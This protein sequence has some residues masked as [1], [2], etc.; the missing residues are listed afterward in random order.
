MRTKQQQKSP[1]CNQKNKTQGTTTKL[2]NQNYKQFEKQKLK[3][4]IQN[5]QN[6]RVFILHFRPANDV[7]F[8][9][10]GKPESV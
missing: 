8:A 1:Y 4:K 7:N 2:M 10:E 5:N 3:I 9:Q 6:F